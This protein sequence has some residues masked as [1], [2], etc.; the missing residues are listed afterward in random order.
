MEPLKQQTVTYWNQRVE[1]FSALRQ[2]ELEGEKRSRWLAELQRYL[3]AG[4]TLDI[5]DVGTGTGFFALLL[6]RQGHRVTGIDLTEGM[7][8]EARRLAKAAGLSAQF[9]VMDAEAPDFAPASFDAIVTRNLT[10]GLP[11]LEKAYQAWYGLLKP[12]GVLVNFDADYCREAP[13]PVLP[14]HHAH[15][16][17]L[18]ST[19]AAYESLKEALRPSQQP[20]PQWDM[21]LLERTGFRQII[22]DATVWRR[23][24]RE[25]DEF[26][27]PTPIFTLAAR[28]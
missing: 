13:A 3:P 11:H 26:Y 16:N 4:R 9:Q 10:W 25:Q 6:A 2:R 28:R 1:G 24:Y 18:P 22:V 8:L 21:A 17:L 7:I 14:A 27:N 12:G 15:Q 20:R 19:L 23:I 5:L